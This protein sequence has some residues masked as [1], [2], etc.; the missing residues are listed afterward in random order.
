MY[1]SKKRIYPFPNE[2][3]IIAFV[4]HTNRLERIP[5]NKNIITETLQKK[6]ANPHV[7]GQMKCMSLIQTLATDPDLLPSSVNSIYDID[8][9]FPW[10]KRLHRNLMNAEAEYG[11]QTLDARYIKPADVGIYRQNEKSIS[12]HSDDMRNVFQ[13]P[14]PSPI[15]V[16]D[17]L[18][19]LLKDLCQFNNE[20]RPIVESSR[21][22]GDTAE[23][24]VNKA[25]DINLRL[26]CIKP[27][28]DGSNRFARLVENL[29]RFN[30]GLPIK[31]ITEDDKDKYLEDMREMQ[32]Q[33]SQFKSPI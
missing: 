4:Y 8:N 13:I 32:H 9:K 16:R 2:D 14:M 18:L 27:F 23:A 5:M 22:D 15:V 26:C 12:A 25:Y 24:L 6:D 28:E 3:S 21:Y 1:E 33:Y 19:D 31:I 7:V 17:H 20:Y 29:L 10:I 30:W 11:M